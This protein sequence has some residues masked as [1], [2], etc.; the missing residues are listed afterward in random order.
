[1]NS[2][3]MNSTTTE[4]RIGTTLGQDQQATSAP[5]FLPVITA[6]RQPVLE[7]VYYPVH[8]IGS[9]LVRGWQVAHLG[10]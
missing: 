2:G 6:A 10:L 1:M 7:I 9:P 4:D 5:W 3:S 8:F